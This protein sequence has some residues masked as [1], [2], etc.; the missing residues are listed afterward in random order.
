[1][2]RFALAERFVNN[3][4]IY[5]LSN[6]QIQ[7][8]CAIFLLILE[9]SY[10]HKRKIH[11][12]SSLIFT[13]IM[14]LAALLI[15]TDIFST[16]SSIY[17]NKLPPLC[18]KLSFQLDTF[19][20]E[21]IMVLIYMYVSI[22]NNDKQKLSI[23]T[24]V[25]ASLIF[26]SSLIMI[27]AGKLD[28]NIVNSRVYA[29]GNIK[30][31]YFINS[32]ICAVLTLFCS[33]RGFIKNPKGFIRSKHR[34]VVFTM[35]VWILTIIL[36]TFAPQNNHLS[37]G[38]ITIM[39]F[40]MYLGLE[41]PDD[42]IDRET[43]LLN[44][45]ALKLFIQEK[46]NIKQKFYIINLDIE[47]LGAIEARFGET[48]KNHLLSEISDYLS[49]KIPFDIFHAKPNS[50]TII[51][52]YIKKIQHFNHVD[53]LLDELNRRMNKNWKI[54]SYSIQPTTHCDFIFYPADVPQNITCT[55]FIDLIY[56]WHEF[57]EE[58]GF[59]RRADA[60]MIQ[61]QER[62][63]IILKIVQD[64]I[65]TDG[66]EMFYQPIYC[67][68]E[69]K[70]TNAESLVRLKD[71]TT[72]GFISP[73]EFIPLAEKNGLIMEL[74]EKIFEQVFSFLKNNKD[75][76]QQ[77]HHI[78]VNLS[79]V[80][81]VD[82]D[83]PELMATL[84]KKHEIAPERI[85]LEITESTSISSG[86][87]LRKNMD[88]LKLLGCTFSM[89]DFGTGYSNLSQIA[90]VDYELIKIDKSLL[91]PCF[92]DKNPDQEK[93]KILLDNL[94][95]MILKMGMKIVVEGVETKEQYDYLESMGVTYIQGY[96][97]SKPLNQQ[98]YLEFLKKNQ[99]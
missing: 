49:F 98:D 66:F 54:D 31:I 18:L 41:T 19:I 50:F 13:G 59:V 62:Q 93:A 61:N 36:Q 87:M 39:V 1:M 51:L 79:G 85:N 60:K 22:V 44:G 43:E 23:V 91:W 6:L 38:A 82:A 24:N 72:I 26:L 2:N 42:Y 45:Y 84:L 4:I 32:S 7:V 30:T 55:E 86:Y 71:K 90:K 20:T 99:S 70:F 12:L 96:Y 94:I 57:S 37:C 65:K 73:E 80:Q 89:D 76:L 28:L 34:Y 10:F 75:D 67:I 33:I 74:S 27:F 17:I 40:L 29:S 56:A 95:P 53:L 81:S 46:M 97:F 47:N 11:I 83:L 88:E 78:E 16:L 58:S 69:R 63:K 8:I 9:I 3:S 92:D 14:I 21:L 15:G 77:L 48:V 35:T 64:A 52:P 25:I 68:P 5:L